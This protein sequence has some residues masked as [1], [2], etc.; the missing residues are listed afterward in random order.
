[1]TRPDA[2]RALEL[3]RLMQRPHG[4]LTNGERL[5][6][7]AMLESISASVKP[8]PD[9]GVRE[10]G[11]AAGISPTTAHR[12]LKGSADLDGKTMKAVLAVTGYCLC[13]GVRK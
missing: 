8:L 3:I 9:F 7:V 5:E 6:V 10:L 13:C 1:M 2:L 4:N 12:V 11:R